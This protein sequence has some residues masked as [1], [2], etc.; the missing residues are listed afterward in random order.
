MNKII[1]VNKT[2]NIPK[3]KMFIDL[4]MNKVR[5]STDGPAGSVLEKQIEGMMV[6]FAIDLHHKSFER[7][8]DIEQQCLRKTSHLSVIFEMSRTYERSKNRDI[9]SFVLNDLQPQTIDALV[10]LIVQDLEK[11]FIEMHKGACTEAYIFTA[12][13]Q[14]SGKKYFGI[15]L[16][17]IFLPSIKQ[18][19]FQKI[20][21]QV[22]YLNALAL[23]RKVFVFGA[24]SSKGGLREHVDNHPRSIT[25]QLAV[26][27]RSMPYE[28]VAQA[29][30]A[31]I[32]NFENGYILSMSVEKNWHYNKPKFSILHQLAL[33]G[34][35]GFVTSEI[36]KAPA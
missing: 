36:A 7:L 5:V 28:W 4:I 17:E 23:K 15:T 3:L 31:L 25:S 8:P 19:M 18:D 26:K 21:C 24:K 10:R 20:D 12:L 11:R 6:S 9:V 29:V 13:M 22:V 14:A 32:A 1:I 27:N 35:K 33:T 16:S 2:E 30:C 34:A